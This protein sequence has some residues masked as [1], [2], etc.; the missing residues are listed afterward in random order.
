M[1]FL[2]PY[3][4]IFSH[5]GTLLIAENNH[6]KKT[7][8]VPLA[9]SIST[10]LF[11]KV[12]AYFVVVTISLTSLQILAELLNTK[13]NIN[14]ELKMASH[15]MQ[16]GLSKAL[17]D[18]NTDQVKSIVTGTMGL[19][20]VLGIKVINEYGEVVVNTGI[21][22]NTADTPSSNDLTNKQNQHLINFFL[23]DTLSFKQ[24][25]D[26]SHRDQPHSMG[27]ITLYSSSQVVFQR[28]KV[29]FMFLLINAV[30]KS[31]ALW[32]IFLYLARSIISKPLTDLR[33]L[34]DK[35]SLE[36][37]QVRQSG[38]AIQT[39]ENDEISVLQNAF[40]EMAKKLSLA[41]KELRSFA[42]DMEHKVIERTKDLADRERVLQLA[43][44]KLEAARLKEQKMLDNKK[45]LMIDVSH[46]LRTPI[47]VLKL[48]VEALQEGL[49]NKEQSYELLQRKLG[50]MHRLIEDLYTLSK[51]EINQLALQYETF[52]VAL[53][54]DELLEPYAALAQKRKLVLETNIQLPSHPMIRADWER[55]YQVFSN[56]LNNSLNYTDEGGMIQVTLTASSSLL[57]IIV[58]DTAPAVTDKD[59][60]RLFDRLYR[61]DSSRSRNT[62]GSGL[63][64]SIC[65]TIILAHAGTI[66]LD[67]STLGGLKVSIT[68]PLLNSEVLL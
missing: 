66:Q 52:E 9:D 24:S 41:H 65:E 10:K 17:W 46:E 6:N 55:L 12:F 23:L 40:Y 67:H 31:I 37:L 2:Y 8:V 44:K 38:L 3:S 54:F 58:E 25:L 49:G 63:G 68:L 57:K 32:F 13:S 64:L 11:K 27:Q 53:L 7:P 1:L 16:S 28:L 45:Q 15:A 50:Q 48:Q 14:S 60:T 26:Y 42:E 34:V 18:Q 19:P 51:A 56:L 4:D 29:G 36:N 5:F 47:A 30:V 61:V 43:N 22:S 35:L 20:I 21:T 33:L 59:L 39:K 62:G